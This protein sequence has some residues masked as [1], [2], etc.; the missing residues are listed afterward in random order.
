MKWVEAIP[1]KLI[2]KDNI[3]AFLIENIITKF[4]VS[5]RLI[6]DNGKIFKGKDMK[7]FCKKFHI[8][9]TFFS[10]YCP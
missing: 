9:Q 2:T 4:E 10:F 5:Q 8:A 6:I 1:M 3:I 7:A